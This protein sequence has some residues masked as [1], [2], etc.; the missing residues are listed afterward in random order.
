MRHQIII[1]V[2]FI[3]AAYGFTRAQAAPFASPAQEAAVTQ[4]C[5]DWLKPLDIEAPLT[6]ERVEGGLCLNGHIQIH[7]DKP[8]L[9]ELGA[10]DK[11]API[12][13]VVRSGGGETD[14][15]MAM[16]DA[17]LDRPVTV[18][19]EALCA[20]SCAN[21]L[22]TAGHR[23]V[24][25][26]D[27]LL[28]YHGGVTLDGLSQI[29]PQLRAIAGKEPSMNLGET[30]I[31]QYEDTAK[32]IDRQEAFLRKA[33][34][35]ST[36]FQWMNLVQHMSSEEFETHCP[37]DSGIIQYSPQTLARFGLTFDE[38]DP[39]N[40]QAEID[41]LEHKLGKKAPICYWRD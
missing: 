27:T 40:T 15:A 13:V 38:Y 32:D 17:F 10:F 3:L 20:S 2:A 23:R 36:L 12:V 39:P 29:L 11:Q 1:G 24:V 34:I 41:A 22:I 7:D 26:P 25:R 30:F 28:L 33:G 9:A 5:L 18:V 37:P 8:V 21:Y 4:A 31:E 35:S 6:V 16:A 14:A 19:A